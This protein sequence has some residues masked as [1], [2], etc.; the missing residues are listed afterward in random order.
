MLVLSRRIKES[1]LIGNDIEVHVLETMQGRVRLGIAAPQTVRI[2][3]SEISR[4]ANG[5]LS[6]EEQQNADEKH[7]AVTTCARLPR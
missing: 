4:A 2:L 6:Q 5:N 7:A 1:I 3:R